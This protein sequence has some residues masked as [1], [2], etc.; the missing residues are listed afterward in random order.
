MLSLCHTVSPEKT[1]ELWKVPDVFHSTAADEE[2][3]E[4][5]DFD[6]Y[7]WANISSFDDLDRMFR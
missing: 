3:K 6:E 2:N 4:R 5:G 7:G 1:S